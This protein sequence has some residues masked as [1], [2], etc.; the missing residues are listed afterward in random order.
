MTWY[1]CGAVHRIIWRIV[2]V[3]NF[4]Y[5]SSL[6]CLFSCTVNQTVWSEIDPCQWATRWV[7][8]NISLVIY[9]QEDNEMGYS[10]DRCS[11]STVNITP[12]LLSSLTHPWKVR[13]GEAWTH[14]YA[15]LT[16]D[17]YCFT[18]WTGASCYSIPVMSLFKTVYLLLSMYQK[19]IILVNLSPLLF[20]SLHDVCTLLS[21]LPGPP[22]LPVS[23]RVPIRLGFLASVWTEGSSVNPL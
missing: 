22:V 8:L 1:K 5:L 17:G 4:S 15:L 16:V 13:T 12:V 23:W 14:V 9:P 18:F 6:F 2:L 10:V 20:L 19:V 3:L 11:I 21:F 7:V